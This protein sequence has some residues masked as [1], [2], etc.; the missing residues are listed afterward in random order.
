MPGRRPFQPPHSLHRDGSASLSAIAREWFMP[1]TGPA[2]PRTP[3]E[4]HRRAAMRPPPKKLSVGGQTRLS[5]RNKFRALLFR[6]D[7]REARASSSRLLF[8]AE[9]TR[10]CRYYVQ[11]VTTVSPFCTVESHLSPYS[12]RVPV[13]TPPAPFED[14]LRRYSLSQ[15]RSRPAPGRREGCADASRRHQRL[16]L[17]PRR[18]RAGC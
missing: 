15:L 17:R 18:R 11:V 14:P 3:R 13:P 6:R 8:D 9:F 10:T 1:G 7:A 5:V 2:A 4:I 12:V 16:V